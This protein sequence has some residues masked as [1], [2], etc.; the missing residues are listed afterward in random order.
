[1]TTTLPPGTLIA[2]GARTAVWHGTCAI[3][4]GEIRPAQL[5]YPLAG[6]R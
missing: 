6:P 1:M 4:R 5:S 2:S 3:C